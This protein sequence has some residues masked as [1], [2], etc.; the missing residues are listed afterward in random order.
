M[1]LAKCFKRANELGT[2]IDFACQI[3][4][5]GDKCI[6][7]GI[8]KTGKLEQDPI[9]WDDSHSYFVIYRGDKGKSSWLKSKHGINI[10]P[11]YFPVENYSGYKFT[12]PSLF[13]KCTNRWEVF[14]YEN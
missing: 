3:D 4:S 14:D 2:S 1:C 8:G 7:I 10:N 11:I 13:R 12:D 5:I 9:I 6:L